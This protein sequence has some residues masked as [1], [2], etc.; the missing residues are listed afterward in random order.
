MAQS[1]AAHLGYV[2]SRWLQI[3][4]HLQ[5]HQAMYPHLFVDLWPK[6]NARFCRQLSELYT[7]AFWLVPRNVQTKRFE[8]STNEQAQIL[9]YLQRLVEPDSYILLVK[10]FLD[11]YNRLGDFKEGGISWGFL[12]RNNTDA[13]KVFWS[14]HLDRAPVLAQLALRVLNTIANSVPCERHFSAMNWLHTPTRSRLTSER[15]NKLLFIQ[16]NRRVLQHKR[17]TQDLEIVDLD[18]IDSRIEHLNLHDD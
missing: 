14:F 16:L 7:L 9:H 4:H 2:K 13:A 6:L 5:Q 12:E 8:L 10:S 1:D 18:E 15:A 11:Y 17:G 3:W